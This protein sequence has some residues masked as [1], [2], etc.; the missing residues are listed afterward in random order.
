VRPRICA[1][2]TACK[3]SPI[4]FLDSQFGSED[5]F[6]NFW[7]TFENFWWDLV[8]VSKDCR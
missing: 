3:N 6:E 7:F 1:E 4:S 8:Y 2:G 5:T